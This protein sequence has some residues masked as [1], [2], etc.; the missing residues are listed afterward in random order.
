[1]TMQ[2]TRTSRL[3]FR[4]R[5]GLCVAARFLAAVWFLASVA[6][7]ATAQDSVPES[8]R[9]HLPSFPGAEGYGSV[10]KGGRGGKVFTVTNLNDSG[11]GSLRAAVKSDGPRIVVF[12]VSGTIDL[13]SRLSIRNPYITIAGQTAPGDGIAIRRYPVTIDADEVV[14]RYLRLRLGDESGEDADALSGRYH[15]N[16]IVDHVSASWSVDETLSIYHCKNVTVQWC[17][18][19]ESLYQSI[20]AKGPH[21]FGGIWGSNYSTY[22]HNLL[23]HHSSRNPRFASGS[24]YTDYRN[25]VVYNWGHNS[26]YGGEKQQQGNPAYDFSTINMVANYYKPGPATR[27]GSV[28]HRIINPS[29]RDGVNDL[30][31]WYVAENYMHGNAEASA[32]N[33]SGGVQPQGGDEQ[34]ESLRLATPWQSMPIRQHRAE[35]A[36]RHVLQHAGASLPRRD[37]VDARIVE[38]VRTGTA[39]FGETYGGGG[40]G[41]IDSQNEVGGWP[42]LSSVPSR[43]DSDG[44]GMS[45]EWEINHGLAPHNAADGSMDTDSDGY[46]NIEEFINGT[47]P[48]V[49]VDYTSPENNISSI[50]N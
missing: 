31:Q 41:I 46:T 43:P 8:A 32:D 45:D 6:T 29:S 10:A 17:L 48:N 30:G 44:D 35:E 40:K 7:I 38:E 39:K 19:A 13:K 26:A 3:V 16:I 37:S 4:W 9:T 50:A 22:H 27:T 15:Q 21:G 14:I 5:I 49:Y 36:Y 25:N 20:H 11:P 42:A 47:N 12:G 33:W 23:A 18:I 1:M 28:G 34:I 24:G 2:E